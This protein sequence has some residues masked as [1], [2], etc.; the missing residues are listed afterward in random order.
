[1]NSKPFDVALIPDSKIIAESVS[2]SNS[3]K[4]LGSLFSLDEQNYFSH[5]SV[6]M[7]QLND[8]G[9]R[10]TINSLSELSK[11]TTSIKGIAKDYNYIDGYLDIEYKKT[12]ELSELQE[13][14]ILALNPLRDGLREK[15]KQRLAKADE[16]T[17]ENILKF[18][19]RSVGDQFFPHITFA[20]F[21]SDQSDILGKLP[22]KR[23]FEGMF[24]KLGLFEMGD[25]GT[26]IKLVKK[27]DL[28]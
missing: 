5:V 27:F 12:K 13:N 20:R 21:I 23:L 7:L 16:L 3:L 15:D 10:K 28:A 4:K 25:N 14:I 24:T 6:Y 22:S 1:M 17:K 2:L 9:L 18:G 19:F 11:T 8:E 26:C